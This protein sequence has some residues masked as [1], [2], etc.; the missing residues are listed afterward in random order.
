MKI[1]AI[2]PARGGSKGIVKK[3]IKKLNGKPLL[4]WTLLECSKLDSNIDVIVSTDDREIAKVSK[5]YNF[6][7]LSLRPDYLSTDEAETISVLQYELLKHEK[8]TKKYYDYVLLLQPTCPLRKV[9]HINDCVNLL[10]ESIDSVV[11]V[12]KIE[13]EHP[14]RMKRIVS[15]RLVNYIDQGFEDMRPR[16]KLPPVYIRNGAVYLTKSDLI[17]EGK[18]I[19]GEACLPYIMSEE[20]SVNID[21]ELDFLLAEYIL[22]NK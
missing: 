12:K 8:R 1:L 3:N 16:Q 18:S 13:S 9:K 4:V 14:F 7:V 21:H 17:R 2:I 20:S 19:V 11:S 5:E 22:K 15:E 6:E 10:E